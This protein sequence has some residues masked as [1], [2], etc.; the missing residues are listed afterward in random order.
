MGVIRPCHSTDRISRLNPIPKDRENLI[1][2]RDESAGNHG[3]RLR[4]FD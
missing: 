1:R 2:F 4:H 3:A